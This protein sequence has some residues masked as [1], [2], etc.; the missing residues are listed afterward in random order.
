MELEIGRLVKLIKKRKAGALDKV[1]DLYIDS[2]YNV[3]KSILI[4]LGTE[5]DIEECVQDVFL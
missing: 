4:N 5:E 3:A 2:V 1:M